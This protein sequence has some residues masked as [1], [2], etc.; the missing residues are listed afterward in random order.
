[1]RHTRGNFRFG[2]QNAGRPGVVQSWLAKWSW[3]CL[4]AGGGALSLV[5]NP[6]L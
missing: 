6:R 3:K 1:L 2:K 4:A 5:E